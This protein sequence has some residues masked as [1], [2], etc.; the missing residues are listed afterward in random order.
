MTR[1]NLVLLLAVLAS[2]LYLVHVQY[3]SRSLFVALDQAQTQ[4]RKLD[5]E[6][7]RLQVA[8]RAEARPLRIEKLARTELHMRTASPAITQY[9]TL[10]PADAQSQP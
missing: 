6:Q 9:V 3:Q 2:A 7:Q 4:A 1:L 5:A 8:K 10:R